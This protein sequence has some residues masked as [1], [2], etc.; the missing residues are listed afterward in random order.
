M[1]LGNAVWGGR[2]KRAFSSGCS[3]VS[4]TAQRQRLHGATEMS[5]GALLVSVFN[6]EAAHMPRKARH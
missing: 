4:S 1:G 3:L 6:T 5:L 2:R